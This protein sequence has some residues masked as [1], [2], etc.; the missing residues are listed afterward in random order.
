MATG[1]AEQ[2][3]P[4][5]PGHDGSAAGTFIVCRLLTEQTDPL[6]LMGVQLNTANITF[7]D[8]HYLSFA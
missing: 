5:P 6:C 4:V 3:L 2:M 1:F 8:H 7:L